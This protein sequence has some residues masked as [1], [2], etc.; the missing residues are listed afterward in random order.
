[1]PQMAKENDERVF[2]LERACAKMKSELKAAKSKAAHAEKAL[3]ERLMEEKRAARE[4]LVLCLFMCA[5]LLYGLI[6]NYGG[7]AMDSIKGG[8][9]AV[10]EMVAE[11]EAG[12]GE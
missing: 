5:V 11:G 9:Q 8:V 12:G 2:E 10:W 6:S 1:M 3:G 4:G 7:H